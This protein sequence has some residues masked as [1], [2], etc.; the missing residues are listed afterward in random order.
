MCACQAATDAV[1]RQ[2]SAASAPPPPLSESQAMT[3]LDAF[4]CCLESMVR[5]LPLSR[6]MVMPLALGALCAGAE[7]GARPAQADIC[8]EYCMRHVHARHHRQHQTSLAVTAQSKHGQSSGG[9]AEK[10]TPR[11]PAVSG[12]SPGAVGHVGVGAVVQHL[13]RHVHGA[14]GG[15]AEGRAQQSP[16]AVSGH[17]HQRRMGGH[18]SGPGHRRVPGGRRHPL[19]HDVL[20]RPGAG[21]GRGGLTARRRR[22]KDRCGMCNFI[23][24]CTGIRY[25]GPLPSVRQQLESLCSGGRCGL[26]A[27][28]LCSTAMTMV[29]NPGP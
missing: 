17:R 12:G 28:I 5:R 14:A 7:N 27:S 20:R 2:W 19:R 22:R 16:A 13:P 10:L 21:A 23:G 1:R 4:S 8:C 9:P 29:D 18:R 11:A 26:W 24:S 3:A 6:R 25:F 15:G